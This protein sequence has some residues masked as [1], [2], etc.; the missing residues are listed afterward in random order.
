MVSNQIISE[1]I[2]I[3][4]EIKDLTSKELAK[5]IGMHPRAYSSY[6]TGE[7]GLDGGMLA[8][9]SQA[10]DIDV[11]YFFLD[12]ES[13]NNIIEEQLNNEFSIPCKEGEEEKIKSLIAKLD[14]IDD[15]KTQ[16]ALLHLIAM[17]TS[18]ADK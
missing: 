8:K 5:K 6:E 16:D 12:E 7:Y 3:L 15:R 9:I 17:M 2:R 14:L 11:S 18:A 10:L 4:R 1:R 13:A